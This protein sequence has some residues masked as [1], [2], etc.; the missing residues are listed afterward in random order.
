MKNFENPYLP[1]PSTPP[2]NLYQKKTIPLKSIG[3]GGPR[4]LFHYFLAYLP[5]YLY[6]LVG[7]WCEETLII[8]STHSAVRILSTHLINKLF[9]K[10]IK[11]FQ[12]NK[13]FIK[14]IWK[15]S[16]CLSWY[17][18]MVYQVCNWKTHWKQDYS[19]YIYF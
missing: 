6:F 3:S 9:S 13:S 7:D 10:L 15:T 8:L 18:L 2:I 4:P 17:S 16:E 19:I 5:L 11:V 12:Y 1:L 14:W